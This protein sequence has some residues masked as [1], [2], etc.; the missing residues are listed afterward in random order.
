MTSS[1]RVMPTARVSDLELRTQEIGRALLAATRAHAAGTF[2]KDRLIAGAL[3]NERFKT[4]L[5]RFVDVF[6]VLKTPAQ[7]HQHLLEYLRQPGVQLPTGLG[8][9][10]LAGGILKGALAHTIAGQ[11]DA[12]ARNFI[13]GRDMAEALPAMETR[14]RQ[15]IGFS[16]DVLGEAC[17][18][19][20]EARGYLARYM[21]LIA[22]LPALTAGWAAR[23]VLERDHL[24]GPAGVVPRVNVSIKISA[25]DGHVSPVDAE[26]SLDRLTAA[27][28]P[29]LQLAG[30]SGVFINFDMEQHALQ[31]LTIRLFKRCCERFDFPAGL[32]LQAYLRT[33]DEAARDLAEW[34][35]ALGRLVTVRLIKG[36]YWDYETIHA[37]MTGWPSPVWGRKSETDACF[38]RITSYLLEHA[39]RDAGSG[40]VTLALGTHNVRSVA[41]AL[42][43]LEA[44]ELPPAA[45]EFQSLRGMAEDLKT[46]LAR[47]I[48]LAPSA[49]PSPW[50]VREYMPIGDMIPGMAYLVRRLL[51]N[52]SN[53]GWLRAGHSANI[54]DDELLAPPSVRSTGSSVRSTDSSV[55]S[56]GFSLSA[57]N[58]F[59][60]EPPRDFSQS[61]PRDAFRQALRQAQVAA[62]SNDATEATTAAAVT[63]AHA[64]F[65]A[66]RD[67]SAERRAAIL[68]TAA[69]DMQHQRD[70]LSAEIILESHKTWSEADADVCEA[71]DFCHY[72]AAAA[73]S[74]FT[75]QPLSHFTGEHD[76]LVH[77]PR[78]VAA[79]IAPWNFPLSIPTGMTAAALV[80][81]NTVVL[82]P[83]GQTP[84]IARRLC[85]IL[86]HAGVPKPALHFLPGPG[87]T[88]GTGLVADPRVALIAFTGSAQVGLE[89]LKTAH[90]RPSPLTTDHGPL[91][92]DPSLF[93][94]PRVIAEM[95]GKNAIIVDDSADLDEAVL[96]VRQ[97]AF[98]YAGQKCS[99]CSRVIVLESIH[100]AFVAR[101]VASAQALIVGDPR[102]PATDLGPVIDHHAAAKIRHYIELGK[103]EATL[104]C[105][106]EAP[107]EEIE[108]RKSKIENLISP[109]IFTHVL[110]THRIA[111]EEIFGPVLSVMQA[112]DF[113]HALELANA[114]P[115]KLTGGLFSR[116][117]WHLDQARR[118]FRVGNLYLNRGITGALVARQPFGGFGLSGLG[119][120]AGGPEYLQHFTDP[121]V[122]TENTLRRGFAPQQDP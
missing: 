41:H 95:G 71:I 61:P 78:G 82:K 109:H 103:H 6:P 111:Q 94:L 1:S 102:D 43:A 56:A 117:P 60:N 112:R 105:P 10:L 91:T 16:M 57:D 113:A 108:D 32:A 53:E 75:P 55:R 19:H 83:S 80:T 31:E 22:K 73:P 92:T 114:S 96:G 77:E 48:D 25:L 2:W 121:R 89:I 33:A 47:G 74:L 85:E 36:A 15:G 104:V 67:V 34:S 9:T 97:S 39:P 101:L 115:F 20:A 87:H 24:D 5:F 27:L 88:V 29:L 38:E 100:D 66:W 13:A 12:M 63:E 84:A 51:E 45:I 4:E 49:T 107:I 50:R 52:T 40:G 70:Q 46:T 37:R 3:E 11:I 106:L 26:G 17:V 81:G 64:A 14:W 79:V 118:E 21:E 116:T 28:A 8:A 7:I 120:K 98:G 42:A 69:T 44:A 35:R 72:Y 93:A 18:S 59:R 68:H 30:K 99:A 58:S 86:W 65:P 90:A 54:T 119:T 122:I 62:I 76:A 23:P 110:P